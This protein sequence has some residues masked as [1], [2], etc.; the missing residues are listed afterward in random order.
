MTAFSGAKI[1]END[2]KTLKKYKEYTPKLELKR[3]AKARK[4]L[5]LQK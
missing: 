1:N 5:E 4:M 3:I 2:M